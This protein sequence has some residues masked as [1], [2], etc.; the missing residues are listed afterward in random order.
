MCLPLS[1]CIISL[2][3]HLSPPLSKSKRVENTYKSFKAHIP[4]FR[5]K[6]INVASQMGFVKISAI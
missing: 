1:M 6:F 5:R 2:N 3:I 4:K